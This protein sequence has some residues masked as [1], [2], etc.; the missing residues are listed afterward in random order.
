[1]PDAT[2]SPALARP[3][4]KIIGEH[5][6]VFDTGHHYCDRRSDEASEICD[7]LNSYFQD[8]K[9][10][11]HYTAKVVQETV[12]VCSLCGAD[13]DPIRDDES[14]SWFVSTVGSQWQFLNEIRSRY[15][16]SKEAR[17]LH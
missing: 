14:G 5:V 12:Q 15:V 7:A 17:A 6:E 1:M 13:W 2:N 4:E 10:L 3:S 16:Q 9:P 8:Y 11:E